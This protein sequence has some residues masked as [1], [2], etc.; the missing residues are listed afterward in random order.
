MKKRTVLLVVLLLGLLVSSAAFAKTVA[1]GAAGIQMTVPEGFLEV[2]YEDISDGCLGFV[3]GDGKIDLMQMDLPYED[4]NVVSDAGMENAAGEIYRGFAA[5]EPGA[6]GYEVIRTGTHTFIVFHPCRNTSDVNVF[7]C[8][9]TAGRKGYALTLRKGDEEITD[10]AMQ[11]VLDMAASIAPG[12]AAAEVEEKKTVEW[13]PMSNHHFYGQSEDGEPN[14]FIVWENRRTGSTVYGENYGGYNAEKWQ[15]YI[16]N[17]NRENGRFDSVN[18]ICYSDRHQPVYSQRYFADGS[19]V[20]AEYSNSQLDFRLDFERGK[21]TRQDWYS[22]GWGSRRPVDAA[23]LDPDCGLS[24]KLIK[25]EAEE[26][27]DDRLHY[28]EYR[29]YGITLDTQVEDILN[30]KVEPEGSVEIVWRGVHMHYD[31]R[32]GEYTKD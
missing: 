14:G 4:F 26:H 15:G 21:I 17:I 22:F 7:T 24:Y 28:G 19:A 8:I 29:I 6:Q 31:A 27:E 23:A 9:T 13:L 16:I 20:Y 1:F 10:A 32:T 11:M 3:F 25:V 5:E 18:M 2:A 12:E 30:M